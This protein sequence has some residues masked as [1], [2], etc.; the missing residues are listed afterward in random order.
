MCTVQSVLYIKKAADD[1]DDEEDEEG[2]SMISNVY[3]KTVNT[4][5]LAPSPSIRMK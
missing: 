2:W 4:H 3:M 5:S 1:D